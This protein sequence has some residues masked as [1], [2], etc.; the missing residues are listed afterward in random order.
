MEALEN[1]I[2]VPIGGSCQYE[3]YRLY[4]LWDMISFLAGE[5]IQRLEN[6]AFSQEQ[7][8]GEADRFG[9]GS[10]LSKDLKDAIRQQLNPL[11]DL[12]KKLGLVASNDR[13]MAIMR[14]IYGLVKNRGCTSR[15]MADQLEE[16]LHSLRME[17]S[18]KQFAFIPE[19]KAE[20][21]E[22]HD[23]FGERV[24]AAFPSAQPEVK[25]AGNCLAADLHTAAVFHFVRASEHGLRALARHLRVRLSTPLEYAGWEEVI[26]AIERKLYVIRTK[27]R[28]RAKSEALEFYRLTLSECETLKD[29]WRNPVSHARHRYTE[30]EAL[31]VWSRVREFMQRLSERVKEC[32]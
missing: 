14:R 12:S 23:L 8:L 26:R 6:L 15:A 4:G 22:Q 2:I 1:K 31:A 28:G 25:D 29:V 19:K 13:R 11:G 3:A 21:F 30:I 7:A 9:A 16:L 10:E 5:L 18:K 32:H 24:S 20:F 27:P 17:A